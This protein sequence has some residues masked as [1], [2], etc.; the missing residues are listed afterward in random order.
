MTLS[1]T[2]R[3]SCFELFVPGWLGCK[4]VSDKIDERA[5]FCSRMT[6]RQEDGINAA[7]LDGRLIQIE[8]NKRACAQ[9]VGNHEGRQVDETL[10]RD[11]GGSQRIAIISAQVACNGNGDVS[12][13]AQSP[14]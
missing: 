4:A 14:S 1:A 9:V 13:C 10:S 8:R 6:V 11:R 12:P 2:S 5:H 3:H 7:K